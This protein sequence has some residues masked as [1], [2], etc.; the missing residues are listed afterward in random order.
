[1]KIFPAIYIKDKKWVRLVKGDCDNKTEYETASR[2]QAGK[3]KNNG[4]KNINN[5]DLNGE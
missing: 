2:D 4:F 5:I 1:M 3:Y